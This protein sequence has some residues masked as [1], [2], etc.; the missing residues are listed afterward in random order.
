MEPKLAFYSFDS[1]RQLF[2]AARDAAWECERLRRQLEMMRSASGGGSD[3]KVSHGSVSDPMARVDRMLD[4]E[5][6]W[7]ATIERDESLMDFAT[8]L[9]YGADQMGGGG[10]ATVLG[11]RHADILWWHYL[12]LETW[13]RTG[14]IVGYSPARCKQLRDEA[15]DV[16]DALGAERVR[17][18]MG[19]AEG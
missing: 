7:E 2:D 5:A 19:L 11:M 6:A 13:D 3:V 9:L 10:V 12:A 16:M 1:A 18:G 8:D 15:F 17:A 4:R 14:A